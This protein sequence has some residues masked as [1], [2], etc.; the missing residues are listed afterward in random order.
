MNPFVVEIAGQVRI[1][2]VRDRR[3]EPAEDLPELP[4]VVLDPVPGVVGEHKPVLTG[5]VIGVRFS[6]ATRLKIDVRG[7]RDLGK[8]IR[9]L[10]PFL[11]NGDNGGR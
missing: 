7:V 3:G 4:L 6:A 11:N 10:L 5:Q 1:E 2:R 8:V 9:V